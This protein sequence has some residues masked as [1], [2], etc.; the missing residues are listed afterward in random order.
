MKAKIDFGF[1]S[2]NKVSE[3]Q[4]ISAINAR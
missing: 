2:R 3:Q 4:L 1:E